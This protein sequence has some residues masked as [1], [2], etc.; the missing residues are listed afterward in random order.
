MVSQM[1]NIYLTLWCSVVTFNKI[2]SGSGIFSFF[3]FFLQSWS[4]IW[5][6]TDTWFAC[7]WHTW[8]L[9]FWSQTDITSTL[10]TQA[11]WSHILTT[12]FHDVFFLKC[13]WR[14]TNLF[15]LS[16]YALTSNI[17]RKESC[18][19]SH[20]FAIHNGV[21]L[22]LVSIQACREITPPSPPKDSLPSFSVTEFWWQ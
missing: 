1:F 9:I 19:G 7:G 3:F 17:H 10:P 16:Y 4:Y 14:L 2:F 21:N 5:F 15:R 20:F 6:N 11:H 12:Y 18:T 13:I 8:Y 22:K